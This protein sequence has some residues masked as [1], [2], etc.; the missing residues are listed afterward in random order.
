MMNA[1]TRSFIFTGFA[2]FLSSY[3]Q[4]AGFYQGNRKGIN[5]L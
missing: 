2:A 5:L 3:K 4:Q 1:F